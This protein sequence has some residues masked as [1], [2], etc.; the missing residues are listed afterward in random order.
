MPL[1][2][3]TPSSPYLCITTVTATTAL[4]HPAPIR[5]PLHICL[6][7]RGYGHSTASAFRQRVDFPVFP[8]LTL[9]AIDEPHNEA[10]PHRLDTH[11]LTVDPNVIHKVDTA[12][13]AHLS[14]IWTVFSRC[15]DSVEGGRRLENLSWRL[16]QREQLIENDIK[17]SAPSLPSNTTSLPQPISAER[18]PEVP[19]LSGSVES[20]A[21][22]DE[23]VEFTSVSAPLEIARPRIL[24]QDSSSRRDRHISSDDFE[25][26]IMSIVKDKAPL[27]APTSSQQL[28]KSAAAPSPSIQR[29]GSTTTESQSPS[30]ESDMASEAESQPSPDMPCRTTVVRGFSPSQVRLP[31]IHS[32][33]SDPSEAIPEPSS[34]PAAKPVQSKKLPTTFKLGAS[35]SSSEQGASVESHLPIAA[36]KT[37][38]QIGVSSEEEGSLRSAISKRSALS[39]QKKQA[40]FSNH[41]STHTIE[42]PDTAIDSDSDDYVDESAID[43]DDDSSDWEDSLE[44]NSGKSSVDEKFFKRVDSTVNLTSRRSLITLALAQNDRSQSTSALRARH[45]PNGLSLRAPPKA[46]SPNDS[47]EAPLMMKGMRSSNLKPIRE[48]PR[49]GAQ[50]IQAAPA[51]MNAPAAHSPRT[52]R[53]TMLATELTDSLRR[54]MIW[55]RQQKSMTANAVK[56][57]HT[58]TD[59]VNLQQHPERACMKKEDDEDAERWNAYFAKEQFDGY[60]SKGW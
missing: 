19:Q 29:S 42:H 55:E 30:K 51:Y 2:L 3:V 26:M 38:F 9:L 59:L 16:W 56:R 53:R 34:E 35:C 54:D 4:P 41:V 58:S 49:S 14:S 1:A 36:K 50:P 46:G 32:H 5:S 40:S 23:A 60:H 12:N 6:V 8:P 25:K 10:M 47:D 15:A 57:R 33:Q 45:G 20:V 52:N 22:N 24:R 18:L 43:D 7:V 39:A 17:S 21:D 11:V 31:S 48:V 28:R 44:D 13:L 37:A 27:S